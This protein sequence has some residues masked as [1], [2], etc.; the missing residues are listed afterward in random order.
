MRAFRNAVTLGANDSLVPMGGEV[1]VWVVW[2]DRHPFDPPH[3]HGAEGAGRRFRT[4]CEN[5]ARRSRRSMATRTRRP[6]DE[7]CYVPYSP[8]SQSALGPGPLA[9]DWVPPHE[10]RSHARVLG[11][12]LANLAL[13]FRQPQGRTGAARV[14]G[15]GSGASEESG[16]PRVGGRREAPGPQ[17][18]LPGAEGRGR[19]RLPTAGRRR[20][21][22]GGTGRRVRPSRWPSHGPVVAYPMRADG[23]PACGVQRVTGR[24]ERGRQQDMHVRRGDPR[25]LPGCR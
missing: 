10:L 4:Q 19:S 16:R 22:R 1:G 15:N 17:Q 13:A 9:R 18:V 6:G 23:P 5:A 24:G 20:S 12:V 14:R 25:G 21:C 11:S 3:H 8:G 2:A 7:R